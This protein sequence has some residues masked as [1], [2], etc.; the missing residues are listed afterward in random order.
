MLLHGGLKCSGQRSF[1]GTLLRRALAVTFAVQIH[2]ACPAELSLT[3]P[4]QPDRLQ[5]GFDHRRPRP[6]E[7]NVKQVDNLAS[8][9]MVGAVRVVGGA[10][11]S[12]ACGDSGASSVVGGTEA[13]M[14]ACSER[15]AHRIIAMDLRRNSLKV[16][17][18]CFL[19]SCGPHRCV[20]AQWRLRLSAIG[21]DKWPW[22]VR[23]PERCVGA[24]ACPLGQH[25]SRVA[26]SIER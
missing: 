8:N 3:K 26:S 10:G 15:L 9:A 11:Q 23:L 16:F 17:L 14:V 20:A 18:S 13:R 2:F 4:R 25:D 12:M 7:R 22:P 6:A 21:T 5:V 24:I 1:R 19:L